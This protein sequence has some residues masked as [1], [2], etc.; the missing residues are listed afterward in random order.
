MN[1]TK[2]CLDCGRCVQRT[3]QANMSWRGIL[4]LLTQSPFRL[5]LMLL[6]RLT[7]ECAESANCPRL[8]WRG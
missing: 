7:G 1:T 3:R 6:E 4:C 8:I 2:H 5:R